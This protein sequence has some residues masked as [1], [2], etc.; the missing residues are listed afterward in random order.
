MADIKPDEISAILRQQLS[1]TNI[2]TEMEE[3]GTV[4][5]VGDGIARV[6]GLSNVGSGELVEFENGVKAI[7]L[8]LEEDNVG[9]VLMGDSGD[10]KEGAKVR[11]TDKIASINVG[12]G[13]LGRV[14]NTLGEPIDGKGPITGQRYEM[15]LERKAPGVIF[16]EPV[17]EPLQTGIKAIDAMIP[18]GRGQR[19]LIIGDRQTGKTA[20]AIDTIINQKEFY[21]AGNPVYCIYVAIGQKAS[22]V[23]GVMKTLS[24]YG[25]LDYSVI[26][27]ASA[28][29]PAPLQFYAPFA[30]A[31]IGEFFRDSGRPALIIYDDLSKQAVAYREVSLLLRR[32]P[33]REA[34]PGDVFYLHSRLLERAAKI[35][36]DDAVARKMNDLPES[37]RHLVKGGGSLTALPIIETQ[38]GDVSAYIPTNVISITDGQIFL[39]GNLF[40]SGIRPAINVG[41]SVSR[42][43]GNAQIKSMKKVAGTLKLDQALYREMEAFSK[44]GGDL[45]PATKLIIDKGARNV[46][47]LKQPQ[48]SPVTVERQVAIIYL[49][50][51]GLLRQVPV[52]KIKEFEEHFLMEMDNK[53]PDVLAEFKK[54]NLPDD[55][56]KRMV[57]LANSLIPQYTK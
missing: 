35:I 44:F 34:Y 22:T 28:S 52:R 27:A 14:V 26:V 56:V 19:E 37:I 12:E 47:I 36:T 23:A 25:A 49:G 57:D 53:L 45:D 3:V 39:E 8:N 46:E 2:S 20:I 17:K 16:R 29:D 51:Q 4:L 43:G 15:P 11:R 48:Y 6:Y 30:G 50:T 54:G 10:I 1:D 9:V 42:V 32:P 33:G 24:D 40:N 31:A 13:M 7:A 55:G 5:Q 38:A 41:I 21:K 18:I